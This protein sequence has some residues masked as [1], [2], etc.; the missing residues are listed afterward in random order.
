[1]R[2]GQSE[3]NVKKLRAGHTDTPL[4]DEGRLQAKKAGL[5]AHIHNIDT[6]VCSPLS[7]A[8]ETAKLVAR[9]LN[10]DESKIHVNSLLIERNFGSLEQQP[11]DPDLDLDGFA[12]VE[13]WDE[14]TTRAKLALEWI[15]TLDAENVLVVS[16][17]S[18]GRAMRSHLVPEHDVK[19]RLQNAKLVQWL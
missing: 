11:Y 4:T 10:F 13:S 8:H 15:N 5:E 2:H 14:L 9:E 18:L 7:R 16:H 12:D 19:D 6:I 3:L 17:G 1:M